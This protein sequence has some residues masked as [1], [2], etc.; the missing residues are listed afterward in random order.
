MYLWVID[1]IYHRWPQRI[2]TD[3]G[4]V[5]GELQQRGLG[6]ALYFAKVGRHHTRGGGC[7]FAGNVDEFERGGEGAEGAGC[8]KGIVVC[9]LDVLPAMS[10][11]FWDL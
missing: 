11:R 4:I 7:A 3:A 1:V 6:F 2:R 10:V 8:G 5:L 9:D